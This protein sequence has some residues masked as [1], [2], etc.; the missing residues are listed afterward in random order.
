MFNTLALDVLNES[1]NWQRYIF[2]E[3]LVTAFTI[4]S[5]VR[6]NS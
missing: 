4:E 5:N 3:E 1:V 2:R 6:L